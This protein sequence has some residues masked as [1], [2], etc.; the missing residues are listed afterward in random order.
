MTNGYAPVVIELTNTANARY[1]KLGVTAVN[2]A[3]E[4]GGCLVQLSELGVY[5]VT[6]EIEEG[7]SYTVDFN[8]SADREQFDFYS[9]SN[10]GFAVI[11]GKLIPTGNGGEFKALYKD[12]GQ[13]VRSVSVELHPD[14]TTGKINGGLYINA[15]N[16]GKNQDQI[17][18]LYVGIE[19]NF[20]GWTDAP[21]RID[22]MIGSFPT[23]KEHARV[24]SESGNNNNLFSRGVKEPIILRVDMIGNMITLTVS[25]VRAPSICFGTT[26][27][28]DV[29]LS[30]GQVG[31]R[32][33]Y[34]TVK[35]DNFT[36]VTDVLPEEMVASVGEIY[37]TSVVEAA[38]A[39]GDQT[40]CILK[41][42]DEA[43]TISKDLTMDLAGNHLTNVTVESGSL[44][45]ID[46]VSGGS[47]VVTGNVPNMTEVDGKSYY[48]ANDNGVYSAHSYEIK[49][50]HIS[51]DPTNDALGYKAELI[52]DD[53]VK[54]HVK[55]I[56]FNLWVSED[57]VVT[58]TI[59]GKT[60]ASLRLKNILKSGGGEMIVYGNA[61]VIF[62]NDQT[63]TSA[64]Y[65][66]TMKEV[67]QTVNAAWDSFT[68]AQQNAVKTLCDRYL[69]TVSTW[70]LNN[71]YPT[72]EETFAA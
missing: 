36:V 55:S 54:S 53:V 8:E 28:T 19:S 62:D 25:L 64:N 56:G 4:T 47:A 44:N 41:D 34:S 67:L 30:Q 13:P 9:S 38:E 49:L 2:K 23:W 24:I 16:P 40:V 50:T 12:N 15:S 18:A 32:S 39:A 60:A 37:F 65:G 33:Q 45:L 48:V 72:T 14:G 58:K 10:G 6:A 61:F 59:D 17:N 71:I 5:N 27:V 7:R 43:I 68:D 42:T 1:I 3:D 63:V 11:D 35:F 69:A 20:E 52:G 46:T 29:D 22:L 21:N 31:I 66:T 26:Y 57:M 51:L 70:G